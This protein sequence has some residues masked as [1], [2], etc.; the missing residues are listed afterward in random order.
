MTKNRIHQLIDQNHV[1]VP[2]FSN[3]FGIAARKFLEGLKLPG[4]DAKLLRDHIELLDELHKHIRQT[5]IW[6]EKVLKD[7]PHIPM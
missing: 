5:E 3:L 2:Q 6:I 1:K 7:N 4:I